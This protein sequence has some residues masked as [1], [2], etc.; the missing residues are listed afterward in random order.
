MRKL[1]LNERQTRQVVHRDHMEDH[2]E[3]VEPAETLAPEDPQAEVARDHNLDHQNI[4]VQLQILTT[5]ILLLLVS[6]LILHM[7][8]LAVQA[9]IM[10]LLTVQILDMEHQQGPVQDM[11]PLS[12]LMQVFN[13]QGLG[14]GGEVGEGLGNKDLIHC[15]KLFG[16]TFSK[17]CLQIV[18]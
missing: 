7:D 12:R 10:E 13:Q 15:V 8:L 14:L 3:G 1:L 16:E 11:V 17:D 18:D 9:L 5:T 6:V 4:L 2:K